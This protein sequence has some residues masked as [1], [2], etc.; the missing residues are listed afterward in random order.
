MIYLGVTPDIESEQPNTTPSSTVKAPAEVSAVDDAVKKYLPY[1]QE[2][3]KKLI[4][5]LVVLLVSAISGFLFY[6]KILTFFLGLF[7][8]KGI[9]IV[10]SS[11]YQFLD[12]AINTGIAMGIVIALPLLIY[13]ILGFLKPALAPKEYRLMIRLVPISL[14]LF[15]VGFAF[16]AW[17]MQFVINI[18]SQT[19]IDFNVSNIWDISRFFSQTIIMG[20]C[21]GLVFELPIIITVLIKLNIVK[22]ETFALNRRYFYVGIII[23]VALLPP[24]DVISLAILTVI[25]LFLFELALLLNKAII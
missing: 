5:I 24:N 15:I 1:L 14:M 11:P 7:N 10:L 21:L 17:V 20:I 8:L 2:I 9:T 6:Q 22:K 19:A 13:Y 18:F 12:L 23:L 3:Q 25:P 16:G 4:T